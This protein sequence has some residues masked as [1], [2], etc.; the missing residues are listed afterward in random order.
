M[1]QEVLPDIPREYTALAEWAAVLVYVL[2]ARKRLPR[3]Q[4]VAVITVGLPALWGVQLLAA[5]LPRPLWTLGMAL[6][7]AAMYGL[8]VACVDVPVRD[9][10]YFV[11]RAFV[12]AELVASLHW[13]LHAYFFPT[14]PSGSPVLRGLLLVAVYG[15]GFALAFV[16]ERRHVPRD[17]PLAVDRRGL[18]STVAIAVITFLMSN[19]S[20][21]S[22]STPFSGRLGLEIFYI[23][24]LVDLAGYVALYAQQGQRLE[25]Q[26]A[27]EVEA[28]NRLL[29]SQHE[30]YLMSKRSIDEV[31]RK[32]HDLKHW[33]TALRAETSPEAKAG[34]L[35]QLEESLRGYATRTETGNGVLDTILTTKSAVCA[36]HGITL[37]CVVDGSAVAFMD[38]MSLSAL[39]GNA[40]D[41]AI[42]SARRVPDPERRLIRVAVYTQEELA[43]IRFENYFEGE[44]EFAD[45]LPRTTKDNAE[46]H[47]YG[48]KNMRQVAEGYGGSLTVHAED[49]W[50]AVRVLLPRPVS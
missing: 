40:L 32:Y 11:A 46:Q 1:I 14:T 9:G 22:T 45:D 50:F 13:Q 37:T 18:L 26:R 6:A 48:L 30:Q 43:L 41:N 42:E 8:L 36:D 3:P 7:V 29:H 34:Y 16:L 21:L 19:I 23:R 49:E 44:L 38:A 5:A 4:L 47:G 25:L 31:N 24:T 20:F 28:I 12:L 39:F 17:Q 15:G 35:D 10:G 27:K 33:I 2:V